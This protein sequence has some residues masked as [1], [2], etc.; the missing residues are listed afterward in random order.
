MLFDNCNKSRC[1]Y[2]ELSI[3]HTLTGKVNVGDRMTLT[4]EYL[5]NSIKTSLIYFSLYLENHNQ[6]QFVPRIK[7]RNNGM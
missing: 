4:Y 1:V 5:I 7:K 2:C 6:V 3:N